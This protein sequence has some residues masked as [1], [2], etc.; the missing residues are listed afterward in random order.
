MYGDWHYPLEIIIVTL[1]H[2]YQIQKLELSALTPTLHLPIVCYLKAA[3][4]SAES[5][6]TGTDSL[7]TDLGTSLVLSISINYDPILS[8]SITA[9]QC[10][11]LKVY[12]CSTDAFMMVTNPFTIIT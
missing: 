12:L 1:I 9:L 5:S 4:D 2:H 3:V 6:T 8:Y 10:P 11:A 7:S